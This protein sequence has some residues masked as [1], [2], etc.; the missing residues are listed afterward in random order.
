MF[1]ILGA[2]AHSPSQYPGKNF[3]KP[4]FFLILLK[5]VLQWHLGVTSLPCE[6]YQKICI[7]LGEIEGWKLTYFGDPN[8]KNLTFLFII[9]KGLLNGHIDIVKFKHFKILWSVYFMAESILTMILKPRFSKPWFW[10]H[11]FHHDF[12]TIDPHHDFQTMIFKPLLH[13]TISI[14]PFSKPQ[15][16][17]TISKTMV[18]RV[19]SRCIY[20]CKGSWIGSCWAT[21]PIS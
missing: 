20:K 16:Q 11:D 6:F 15:F 13:T 8:L 2:T 21:T 7:C 17:T 12:Q 19:F 3:E 10:N 14:P 5:F 1:Y 9:F 18:L 4:N